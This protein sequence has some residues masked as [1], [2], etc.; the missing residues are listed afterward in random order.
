VAVADPDI[1]V[2]TFVFADLAGFTALTEAHGDAEALEIATR[3]AA[4]VRALLPEHGAEEV[5]T[6]GDEVMIRVTEPG[7][8]VKLGL[9][10]TEQLARPGEPPVRVGMHSGRAVRRDRDWFGA[11]VNLASRVAGA[12][13]PGE[14][15][16]TE[17]T[18]QQVGGNDAFELT[19]R[20]SSYF[21]NIPDPVPVYRAVGA[22]TPGIEL[23]ID[24]VCRM[25]VDPKRAAETRHRRGLTYHFCS[26]EC[27]A[28]FSARPRRYIAAGA[29]ARAA[30]RG[31]LINLAAF[32]VLGA[33]HLA[34]SIGGSHHGSGFALSSL[35]F[36]AW[37]IVLVFHF[38]AVRR[39]L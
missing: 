12:A 36:L 9:R 18:R 25:A 3:F 16:V 35:L 38:R 8:A 13:R 39:V 14:V 21:K 15:L 30:R 6:I 5:K 11:T 23:E 34:G 17:G 26:P 29:A 2:S 37:A 20:G 31:F 28:A 24:P 7:E 22:G 32:L 10:I 27:A 19:P 4:R 33:V 1:Q